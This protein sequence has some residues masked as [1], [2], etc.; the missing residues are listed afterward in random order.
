MKDF[1]H[2]NILEGGGQLGLFI[3][4]PLLGSNNECGFSMQQQPR[5]C[6]LKTG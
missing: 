2:K 4:F 6:A 5:A 1:V 3:H